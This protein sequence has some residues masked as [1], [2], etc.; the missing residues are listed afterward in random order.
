MNDATSA[1]RPYNEVVA[2]LAHRTIRDLGSEAAKALRIR[3]GHEVRQLDCPGHDGN[4]V[5]REGDDDQHRDNRSV[6]ARNG[7]PG[8]SED[9][10]DEGSLVTASSPAT[11]ASRSTREL[12]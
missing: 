2:S 9:Q 3:H 11:A 12:R 8:G 7:W 1:R 5:A 10:R 4:K 6:A